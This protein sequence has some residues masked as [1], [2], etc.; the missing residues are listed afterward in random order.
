MVLK[1]IV[2]LNIDT[3]WENVCVVSDKHKEMEWEVE[4]HNLCNKE[5]DLQ[6]QYRHHKLDKG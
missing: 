1:S 4:E 3:I 5:T 2:R 6:E